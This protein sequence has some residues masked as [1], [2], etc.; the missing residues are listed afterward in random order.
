VR[1]AVVCGPWLAGPRCGN[2]SWNQRNRRPLVPASSGAKAPLACEDRTLVGCARASINGCRSRQASPRPREARLPLA[3]GRVDGG[4]ALEGSKGSARVKRRR[5]SALRR[6]SRHA[7]EVRSRALER[8]LR[9]DG[10]CSMEDTSDHC[11]SAHRSREH[12]AGDLGGLRDGACSRERHDHHE[13]GDRGVRGSVRTRH[14]GKTTPTA[15]ARERTCDPP[16]RIALNVK[17]AISSIAQARKRMTRREP[18]RRGC[19]YENVRWQKSVRRIELH[20][21]RGAARQV[22]GVTLAEELSPRRAD[23]RA[24]AAP[25]RDGARC[26]AALSNQS[27]FMV[28]AAGETRSIETRRKASRLFWCRHRKVRREGGLGRAG[29]RGACVARRASSKL[30]AGSGTGEAVPVSTTRG[31]RDRCMHGEGCSSR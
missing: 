26:R 24:E 12:E 22:G 25:R 21:A 9:G 1:R 17:Q 13:G 14:D 5:S 23:A 20:P 6:P 4:L 31:V 16:K 30:P 28:T 19:S 7:D 15:T 18:T 3:T 29:Q 27:A 2:A 8:A 10:P 11:G